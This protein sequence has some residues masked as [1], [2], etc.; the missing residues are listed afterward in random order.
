MAEPPLSTTGTDFMREALAG[1]RLAYDAGEYPVGAVVVRDGKVV[2]RGH[3]AQALLCDPTAHAEVI[4]IRD[5]CRATN[6]RKLTGATLYTTLEPCPMCRAAIVEADIARVVFG[7][8][9]FPWIRDVKFGTPGAD[10]VGPVDEAARALF[11]QRLR[12]KGRDEVFDYE[13]RS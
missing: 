8:A 1:A 13:V 11:E 9:L 2:G 7:A 4:A 12:E 6:A 5:A 10:Y 3:N